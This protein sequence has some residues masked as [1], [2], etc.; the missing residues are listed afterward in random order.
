MLWNHWD[1]DDPV[2]QAVDGVVDRLCRVR[3]GD[4][5]YEQLLATPLF[6]SFEEPRFRHADVLDAETAVERVSS[7][8]AI[9]AATAEER[10]AALGEVRRILG[11]G[12]IEFSMITSVVAADRV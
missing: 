2:L 10:T 1:L 12:T 5:D 7:V 9:V 8:S 3:T 11:E 4:D 6:A